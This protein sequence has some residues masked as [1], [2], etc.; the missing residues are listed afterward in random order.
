MGQALPAKEKGG[1]CP[2]YPS[3]YGFIHRGRP[4]LESQK[5]STG[6][7]RDSSSFP[8]KQKSSTVVGP[9]GQET[10]DGRSIHSRIVAASARTLRAMYNTHTQAVRGT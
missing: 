9:I 1:I 7:I 4:S 2:V 5:D 6:S 3:G 10:D 8:R